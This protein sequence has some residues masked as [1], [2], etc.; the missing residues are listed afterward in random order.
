MAEEN[1]LQGRLALRVEGDWW[2]AYYALPDT[3]EG[4]LHLGSIR[5][6][7]VMKSPALKQAFMDCMQKLVS[8]ALEASLGAKLVWPGA[9]RA[10][11]HERAGR[12]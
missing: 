8:D 12:A 3:M 11:E 5:I 1:K 2:N 7:P 9:K 6:E 4:A 10:P